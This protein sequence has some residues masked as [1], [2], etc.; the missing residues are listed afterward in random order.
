MRKNSAKDVDADLDLPASIRDAFAVGFE[1]SGS[2]SITYPIFLGSNKALYDGDV[3]IERDG[4]CL[5]VPF[6]S[7][8]TYGRPSALLLNPVARL[9]R[10][11]PRPRTVRVTVP[12]RAE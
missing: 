7:V 3:E 8:V 6:S 2:S 4:R 5:T 10:E 9:T 12:Q 11:G 1:E